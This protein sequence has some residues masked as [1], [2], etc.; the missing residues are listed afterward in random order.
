MNIT[1]KVLIILLLHF[2]IIIGV[3]L[4]F[5]KNTSIN[6]FNK[7][8]AQQMYETIINQRNFAI[9]KAVA[10]GNYKCCIKPPCTMCYMQANK[11]NNYTSGTCACDDL[12]AQGKEPCPQCKEGICEAEEKGFCQTNILKEN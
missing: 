8:N 10:A 6:N 1:N 4:Y 7:L 2:I 3:I 5:V 12:I 11:W 9:N